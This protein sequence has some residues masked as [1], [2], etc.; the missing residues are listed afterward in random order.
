LRRLLGDR[1]LR[2]RSHESRNPFGIAKIQPSD[3][4]VLHDRD[5]VDAVP[6]LL[7]EKFHDGPAGVA[8]LARDVARRRLLAVSDGRR[9]P[10]ELGGAL[11]VVSDGARAVLVS[12]LAPAAA[13]ASSLHSAS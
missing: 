10:G 7:G 11:A 1:R 13:G 8:G 4:G 5:C 9:G 12:W 6:G 3:A 2:H